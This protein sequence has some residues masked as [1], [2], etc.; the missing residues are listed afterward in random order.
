[1]IVLL[2]LAALADPPVT[3][4]GDPP[5]VSSPPLD[6]GTITAPTVS[7]DALPDRVR[8]ASVDVVVLSIV[9][10]SPLTADTVQEQL[11][12]VLNALAACFDVA[13]ARDSAI[14]DGHADAR[15]RIGSDGK[16][17]RTDLLPGGIPSLTFSRCATDAWTDLE[18]APPGRSATLTVE[19]AL[20]ARW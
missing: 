12:P 17:T 16:V 18:L 13:R 5:P 20:R 6:A 8:T 2:A 14:G 9:A 7:P 3:P 11:D 4:T 10:D 19:V 1:V 15:L